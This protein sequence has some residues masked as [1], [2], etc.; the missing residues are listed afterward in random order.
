MYNYFTK[1]ILI[2]YFKDLVCVAECEVLLVY[3]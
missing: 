2:K 3:S 1:P